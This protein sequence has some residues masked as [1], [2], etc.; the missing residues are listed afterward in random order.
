MSKILSVFGATGTQ[1]SSVVNNVLSNPIL[2]KQYSIRAITR[3]PASSAAVA[4]ASKVSVVQGDL[5]DRAS[6][7]VALKG[8]HTVFIVTTPSFGPSAVDDEFQT[9]KTAV[10]VAVEQGVE[11]IIFSTLPSITELS[12][13]KLTAV[14][15]FD[16]KAKIEAYIRSLPIKSAFVSGAFFMENLQSQPFLA[17]KKAEDGTW[18]LERPMPGTTLLPYIDATGD[19][20]KFVG[21]ILAEP[22]R[23]EGKRLCAAQGLY[24]LEELCAIMSKATGEK[25]VFKQ[26]S[27]EAFKAGMPF[28]QDLFADAMAGLE[29]FGYWGPETKELIKW[30]AEQVGGKLTSLEEFLV[31]HP[32]KL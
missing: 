31:K 19:L 10:D 21:A 29:E 23:L 17:P 25:V 12:G 11:Y 4:L 16:A 28:M 13:G 26:I 20:G 9:V 15:A 8:T 30:G 6:L 18:V 24:A 2:S 14:T 5:S 27:M 3:D 32:L 7:T 22:E 1:G